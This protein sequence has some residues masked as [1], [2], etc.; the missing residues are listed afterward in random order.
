MAKRY[1]RV[2]QIIEP[3]HTLGLKEIHVVFMDLWKHSDGLK[4]EISDGTRSNNQPFTL[5]NEDGI[6]DKY[7]KYRF[8]SDDFLKKSIGRLLG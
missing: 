4:G 2:E 3:V 5:G 1:S 7:G 6:I 8:L